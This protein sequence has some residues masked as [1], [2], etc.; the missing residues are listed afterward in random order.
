MSE[1]ELNK[2]LSEPC[3]YKHVYL[4][5]EL[6]EMENEINSLKQMQKKLENERHKIIEELGL[7]KDTL[8]PSNAIDVSS[9]T[10]AQFDKIIHLLAY[11]RT[12]K[13]RFS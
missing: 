8:K 2:S 4:G 10:P 7:N 12:N 9:I 11:E 1:E 3:R 6:S 5:V 13:R